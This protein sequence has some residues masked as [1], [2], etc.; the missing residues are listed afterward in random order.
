VFVNCHSPADAIWDLQTR[1]GDGPAH[2]FQRKQRALQARGRDRGDT[3]LLEHVILVQLSDD[4]DRLALEAIEQ[5]LRRCQANC[6]TSTVE[7][8]VGYASAFNP[9]VD[10][11][12]NS[13]INVFLGSNES[14]CGANT[15]SCGQCGWHAFDQPAQLGFLIA[16]TA[17]AYN[18]TCHSNVPIPGV[19]CPNSPSCDVDSALN[20]LSHETFEV[21]SDPFGYGWYDSSSQEIG[22]KCAPFFKPLSYSGT[23]NHRWGPSNGYR[24]YILQEEWDNA[25]T[26]LGTGGGCTQYGPT[27][28]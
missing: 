20:N 12:S 26:S 8:G 11:D 23:A 19:S 14:L 16:F 22:D 25:A 4:L 3:E 15:S 9:K 7:P 1:F 27:W 10:P 5:E 6:A 2:D 18:N 24:Y 17:I 21:A 13:Q 28:P